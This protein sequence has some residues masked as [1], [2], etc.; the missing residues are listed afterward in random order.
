M[1]N[2]GLESKRA[3]RNYSEE[4]KRDTVRLFESSSQTMYAFCKDLGLSI[5]MMM[6][7]KKQYGVHAQRIKAQTTNPTILRTDEPEIVSLKKK[8]RDLE[9]ELEI[10]KKSHAFF[11]R[12]RI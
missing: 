10:I 7:W 11:A 6:R 9:V 12:D 1:S 4:Y 3:R 2:P 8:I 5:S